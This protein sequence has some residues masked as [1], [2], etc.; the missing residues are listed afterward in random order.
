MIVKRE[1]VW[2]KDHF[3]CHITEEKNMTGI[4]EKGLI[5]LNG[6]RC[7]RVEDNRKGV[8]FL[9]GL[10]HVEDWACLM[11]EQSE[12]QRLRLLRFNLKKRKWYI[13]NS[14]DYSLGFYLPYKV[15]PERISYLDIRDNE[16]VE[17]PL[18]RLFDLDFLYKINESFNGIE[19][20]EKLLVDNCSLCWKPI[21][22]YERI[23]KLEKI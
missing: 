18:T 10:N 16:G 2:Y 23:K 20:D 1:F 8:F 15:L 7:K 17:L 9:D 5:P 3:V 19:N 14:S 11:Y 6:E 22:E 21:Q 4:I 13:D 12:L